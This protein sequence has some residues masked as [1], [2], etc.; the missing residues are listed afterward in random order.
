MRN[1][2]SLLW[3]EGRQPLVFGDGL[4]QISLFGIGPGQ[5]V[6]IEGQIIGNFADSVIVDLRLRRSF[7]EE[8]D[9]LID[10]ALGPV[11]LR[12]AASRPRIARALDCRPMIFGTSASICFPAQVG[13]IRL[14]LLAFDSSEH[15][16]GAGFPIW[17]IERWIL[18][19]IS[20]QAPRATSGSG[21]ADVD[22]DRTTTGSQFGR[23]HY[24]LFPMAPPFL[25]PA[26]GC[27]GIRSSRRASPG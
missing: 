13:R 12:P 27:S 10:V 21:Q 2:A 20:S 18:H 4:I 7:L 9:D 8:A 22:R 14:S 26:E 15:L 19:I 25:R 24:P 11:R 5:D 16:I 23:S 3:V 6:F 1:C 17:G